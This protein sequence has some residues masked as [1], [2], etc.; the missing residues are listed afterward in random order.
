MTWQPLLDHLTRLRDTWPSP[1]WTWDARFGAVASTFEAT[2][3]SAVR[4]SAMLAFPRG[5]TTKSL[6]AAP[7]DM[8]ALAERVGGLRP[9][10]RLLAGDELACPTLFGLWWPWGDGEKITLRIGSLDLAPMPD[11]RALFGA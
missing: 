9:R 5:W 4:V 8:R 1:P 7:A 3:E 10:Q 6:E 11:V 2:Q